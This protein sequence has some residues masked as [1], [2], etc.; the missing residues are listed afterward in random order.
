MQNDHSGSVFEAEGEFFQALCICGWLSTV[1]Y[2]EEVDLLRA[3]H[4]HFYATFKSY[5]E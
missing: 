5:K 2:F 1:T 3:L 4:L